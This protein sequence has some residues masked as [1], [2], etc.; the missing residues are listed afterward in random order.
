MQKTLTGSELIIATDTP[1]HPK[2]IQAFAHSEILYIHSPV[3][4]IP[5]IN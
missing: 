4:M 5:K 1:L 2:G 3:A